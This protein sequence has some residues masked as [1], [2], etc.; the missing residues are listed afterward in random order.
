MNNIQNKVHG[1]VRWGALWDAIGLP[2]ETK[3][4]AQIVP[5]LDQQLRHPVGLNAR[6]QKSKINGNFYGELDTSGYISDDTILTLAWLQSVI[7]KGQI[8]IEDLFNEHHAFI[9]RFGKMWFGKGTLK[10]LSE[11]DSWRNPLE[12]WQF[13]RGNGVMMKQ[14]PYALDAYLHPHAPEVMDRKIDAI[15]QCT[16]LTPV[17]R[18]TAIIHNRM[19]KHLLD[20]DPA[21]PLNRDAILPHMY[22]IAQAYEKNKLYLEWLRD[23]DSSYPVSKIIEQLH[24]Q[25]IALQ[26]NRP[27]SLEQILDT[28]TLQGENKDAKYGFHVGSTFGYVYSIFLQKQNRDGLLDTIRIGED[29]D[30]QAAIIGNMIG[31]YKGEFYDKALLNQL[32]NKDEIAALLQQVDERV[33]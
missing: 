17:A 16:H 20:Q 14:F 28:Y 22:V 2:F 19:L 1:A 29:T 21:Q 9:K 27:Y 10:S 6:T 24:E 18:L 3:K 33:L 25:Y 8:E 26:A 11:M 7:N 12:A 4:K 15:A 13:S 23:A 30:T 5:L 31:A 32:Q